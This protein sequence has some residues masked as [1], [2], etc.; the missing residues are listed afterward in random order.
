MF[1]LHS[2]LPR[3]DSDLHKKIA[4]AEWQRRD[5]VPCTE[6]AGFDA[7][8]VLLAFLIVCYKAALKSRL[9]F[10]YSHPS[11]FHSAIYLTE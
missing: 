2:I 6:M 9:A 3:W 11:Q 1:I 8:E 10:A 5:T 4:L 7:A